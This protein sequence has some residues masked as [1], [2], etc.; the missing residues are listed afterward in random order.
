MTSHI[1]L[2]SP[3]FRHLI[4]N[5]FLCY[6]RNIN[7]NDGTHI[8]VYILNK[9]FMTSWIESINYWREKGTFIPHN[10]FYELV[11]DLQHIE[12]FW[13]TKTY[14]LNSYIDRAIYFKGDSQWKWRSNFVKLHMQSLYWKL[15]IT[16]QTH[17]KLTSKW[18]HPHTI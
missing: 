7:G 10:E 13:I 11:F 17:E 6:H 2:K 9:M 8:K 18:N 15:K 12:Y 1:V 14:N 5:H 3:H 4:R 16:T